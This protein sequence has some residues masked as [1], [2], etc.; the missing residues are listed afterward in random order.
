VSETNAG[1]DDRVA[2]TFWG[3]ALA[4]FLLSVIPF[5]GYV[6]YPFALLGTWAHEMGH[7]LAAMAT[8]GTFESLELYS[9]LGG[10]AYYSGAGGGGLGEAF[11]AAAGLLAPAL[12]GGVVVALGSRKGSARW[13]LD[14][15]GA[16]MVVSAVVFIR[17]P[18]G[19]AATIL[20][21]AA[22]FAV[23]HRASELVEIGVAQFVGV[24]LSMEALSDIDYMFTS[25]FGRGGETVMSDTE[26][27][28]RQLG[29]TYWF[30]GAL[31]AAICIAILACA[32]YVAWRRL[33]G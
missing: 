10:V 32:Y 23:G 18:F 19:F 30:W 28:A 24:R 4:S 12:A 27:I 9:N 14:V 8:G 33:H 31:I 5:G 2:R 16:A 3:A 7:G 15:I 6:L 21:G 26:A 17:N 1:P 11:I 29:F 22:L 13:V 25:T 20:I